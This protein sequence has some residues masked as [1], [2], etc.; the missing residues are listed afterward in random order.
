MVL[1][2]V[3]VILFITVLFMVKPN[4]RR[5]RQFPVKLFAHRGL[6]GGGIPENSA[7]AFKKA[8]DADFGVE[9]DVRLTKDK[10]LVVFH[11]D[12]LKR[13]CGADIEVE[14]LTYDELNK[15]TLQGT[16]ETIP[17]FSLVLEVLRGMPVICE[18][19][20]YPN[21]PVREICEAVCREIEGYP[22]FISIESFNPFV[23]KWFRKNRPDIIRGQ[24][25]MNFLKNREVLRFD[26]AFLMTHLLVNVISRPDFIAYRFCDESAGFCLC[27][28]VFRPVCAAWTPKGEKEIKEAEG[29]FNAIIFEE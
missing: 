6:H 15:Y 29:K 22:G 1:A 24:L 18:I 28:W 5:F 26:Q 3:A 7:V 21:K 14:H 19:K 9:L 2:A 20:S 8:A 17:L 16:S 11:D 13:L 4:V 10:K 25:S 12:S 23:L 27:R